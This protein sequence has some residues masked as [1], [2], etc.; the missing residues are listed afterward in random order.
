LG[1][2][3]TAAAV[4]DALEAA[5]EWTY[6]GVFADNEVAIRLYERLGFERIGEPGPDLLLV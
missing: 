4:R 6:L 3:V 1:R 2:I 5:S